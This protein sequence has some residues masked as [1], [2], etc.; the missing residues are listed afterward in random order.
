MDVN[1]KIVA[2]VQ[3]EEGKLGLLIEHQM[4]EQSGLGESHFSIEP[5]GELVHHD[6]IFYMNEKHQWKILQITD[7]PLGTYS[8]I[9]K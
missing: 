2:I 6:G 3:N 5:H 7:V 1:Y 8:S 9:P 4:E